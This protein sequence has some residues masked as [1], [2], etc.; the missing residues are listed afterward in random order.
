MLS[1]SFSRLVR[2]RK[3]FVAKA[4][5]SNFLRDLVFEVKIVSSALELAPSLFWYLE[6]VVTGPRLSFFL[7][8]ESS[9]FYKIACFFLLASRAI[10]K[11]SGVKRYCT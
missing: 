9:L 1:I 6:L 11:A 2:E 7:G 4:I 8:L 3:E 5:S 10:F